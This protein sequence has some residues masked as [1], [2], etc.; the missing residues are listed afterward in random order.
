MMMSSLTTNTTFSAVTK[1]YATVLLDLA[2]EQSAVPRILPLVELLLSVIEQTPQLIPFLTNKAISIDKRV[3]MVLD[4][5]PNT[6]PPLLTRFLSLVIENNRQDELVDILAC[7]Q[8]RIQAHAGI[9][10]V[11]V[12]TAFALSETLKQSLI[13]ALVNKFQLHQVVLNETV[14][15]TL[16]AGLIVTY[17]GQRLDATLQSR[18]LELQHRL[19]QV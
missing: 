14:E 17:N 4:L 11:Q 1:Q 8:Q 12:T 3:G 15:P 10:V 7:F 16:K 9:G 13:N 6:T 18:M 2:T 19:Q 5:L